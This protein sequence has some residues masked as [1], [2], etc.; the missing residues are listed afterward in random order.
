[1]ELSAR[2]LRVLGALVEKQLTTPDY[3]PMSLN[4][5]K[6]A[7]NQ[8][9][10]RD[11]VMDMSEEEVKDTLIKLNDERLV[12]FSSGQGQRVM[13]YK[14]NLL[15][16]LS[17][18]QRELALLAVLFL[19]GKQT[20]G[21][22][23]LR[24]QRMHDFSS[25]SEVQNFM[26]AMENREEPLVKL[27]AR[28]PGQKEQRYI[29]LLGSEAIDEEEPEKESLAAVD[30]ESRETLVER[31]EKLEAEMEILKNKIAEFMDE[32]SD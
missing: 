13:K 16:K 18:D 25:V 5:L 12:I 20:C 32:F 14:H 9:S 26:E 24:T 17:I 7:C 28:K 2:E 1:M 29:H 4:G 23:R 15:E 6:N 11:P 27:L 10:N 22:L 3:Y 31:I 8:K 21:E 30:V 19:R